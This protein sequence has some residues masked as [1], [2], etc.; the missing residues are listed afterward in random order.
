M[1]IDGAGTACVTPTPDGNVIRHGDRHRTARP[2]LAIEAT[3]GDGPIDAGQAFERLKNAGI[4]VRPTGSYGLSDCLRV[5]IGSA[6]EME[7]MS[8]ELERV[9]GARWANPRPFHAVGK[10][11]A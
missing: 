4:I 7:V 8:S 5:T 1:R 11:Q 2:R 10:P 9:A 6:E 3:A